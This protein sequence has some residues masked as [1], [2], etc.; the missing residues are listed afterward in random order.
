M[1]KLVAVLLQERMR[2]TVFLLIQTEAGF[3]YLKDE[4][5]WHSTDSANILYNSLNE[6]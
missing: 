2:I 4:L 6:E 3:K 5:K 1:S